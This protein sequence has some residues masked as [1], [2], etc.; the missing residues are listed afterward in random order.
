LAPG[1]KILGQFGSASLRAVGYTSRKP[2]DLLTAGF[3]LKVGFN[4]IINI[5]QDGMMCSLYS[6]AA[7]DKRFII[8]GLIMMTVT[9]AGAVAAR[10]TGIILDQTNDALIFQILC[11]EIAGLVLGLTG[12]WIKKKSEN[13]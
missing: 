13:Y 12:L 11:I 8:A 6:W 3:F 1:L 10:T 9:Y 4:R 5:Y 2:A 7:L